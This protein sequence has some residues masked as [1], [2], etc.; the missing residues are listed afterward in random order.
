MPKQNHRPSTSS[1]TL[2]S[3]TN[4]SLLNCNLQSTLT[5]TV[6]F[7]KIRIWPRFLCGIKKKKNQEKSPL[8]SSHTEGGKEITEN[9]TTASSR[10]S[11]SF[12][13]LNALFPPSSKVQ[14]GMGPPTHIFS[15]ELKIT[16]SHVLRQVRSTLPVHQPRKQSGADTQNLNE[17]PSNILVLFRHCPLGWKVKS[18]PASFVLLKWLL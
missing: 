6:T 18:Y 17:L 10:R 16:F 13:H 8:F 2:K 15:R 9:K 3:H 14:S 1:L 12:Q 11:Q 7:L 5:N 4:N